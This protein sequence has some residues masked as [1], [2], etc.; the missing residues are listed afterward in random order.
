ME[1]STTATPRTRLRHRNE[2][3]R[4]TTNAP[5]GV[6]LP[7]DRSI[8]QHNIARRSM[9]VNTRGPTYKVVLLGELGVGKTALFRRLKD[10]TFDEFSTATA[11]IDSCTKVTKVDGETI[12]VCSQYH[13][14]CIP[15]K[16]NFW[17]SYVC[18]ASAFNRNPLHVCLRSKDN[19]LVLSWFCGCHAQ[20]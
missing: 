15:R 3:D 9:A 19:P 8:V 16:H 20:G 5:E 14:C 7:T 10:N 2:T 1:C 4:S 12:T 17:L 11:G 6:A 13:V 18:K